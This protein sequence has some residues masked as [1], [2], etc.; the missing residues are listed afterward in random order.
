MRARGQVKGAISDINYVLFLY[1]L[2]VGDGRIYQF[3]P[4]SGSRLNEISV[5]KKNLPRPIFTGKLRDTSVIRGFR[6]LS[7]GSKS[8]ILLSF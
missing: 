6:R 3:S 4:Y 1:K 5:C 2:Q 7:A 8:G